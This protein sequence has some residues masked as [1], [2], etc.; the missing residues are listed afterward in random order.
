[1]IEKLFQNPSVRSFID[2]WPEDNAAVKLV[3][4][5]AKAILFRKRIVGGRRVVFGGLEDAGCRSFVGVG[6]GRGEVLV[7]TCFSAV[8][9]GTEIG[10][11]L[12]L[13][14]FHQERPYFPGYSGCGVVRAAGRR[15]MGFRKGR[16][17]AGNL[18]H[19]GM[20]VIAPAELVPVPEG[21]D[22]MEA[23]FVTLGVISLI[24][25]KTAEIQRGDK[26]VI[27]GQ[28]ILGQLADQLAALEGAGEVIAVARTAAKREISLRNGAGAFIALC[29]NDASLEAVRADVVIDVTGSPPALDAALM[30]ARPEGTVVLLGSP[31]GYGEPGSWPQI[32]YDKDIEI[33]GA[34][35]RN[36]EAEGSSYRNEAAKFLR[37]VAEKKVKLKHLITSIILP[38]EAPGFY[39]RLASGDRSMI[40]VVMDWRKRSNNVRGTQ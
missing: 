16:L 29:D 36:L 12:D 35:I 34:H 37:L 10:Y 24:G 17:V 11:Y 31:A 33:K 13:P 14:N 38:E 7:E 28:G 2:F 1:M 18:K 25:V 30:M 21:L 8:S 27:L 22:G 6:P 15:V 40:G 23:A 19:S 9:P 4:V 20:N 5:L 26:V 3:R 39:Q 32:L